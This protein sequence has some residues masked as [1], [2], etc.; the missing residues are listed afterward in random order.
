MLTRLDSKTDQMTIISDLDGAGGAPLVSNLGR[1][2]SVRLIAV[3][4][5][6]GMN[7]A[8]LFASFGHQLHQVPETAPTIM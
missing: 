6:L 8:F 4:G 1:A 5:G 7:L 2:R 3:V